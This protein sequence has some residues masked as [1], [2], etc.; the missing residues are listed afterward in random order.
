MASSC[1]T[2]PLVRARPVSWTPSVLR[3]TDRCPGHARTASAFA[4]ITRSRTWNRRSAANS[5]PR[6]ATS[7]SQGLLPGT[8]RAPGARTD[9]APSR[10]KP[11]SGNGSTGPGLKSPGATMKRGQKSPPCWEW[12]GNNSRGWSC[13]PR[14]TSRLSSAPR[15]PTGWSCCRNSSGPSVLK[16]WNRIWHCGR[17]QRGTMWRASTVR[18]TSWRPVPKRRRCPF[19]RAATPP[20]HWWRTPRPGCP[21]CRLPS[22]N[23]PVSWPAR[24]KKQKP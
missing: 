10:R 14:A 1:S 6:G 18:W 15:R 20:N 9:S 2:V 23:A 4:A 21:G 11:S 3:C 19:S 7:K 5:P 16:P 17:R 22:P 12:T 24:Q 13:C 8:S